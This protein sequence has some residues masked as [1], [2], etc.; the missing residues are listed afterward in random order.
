V[1]IEAWLALIIAAAPKST[2]LAL[3]IAECARLIK[4]YGDTL[5]RGTANYAAIETRVIDPVLAGRTPL[6]SGIDAIA[7]ARTAALVEPDGEAL[8]RC[9]AEI[10]RNSDLGI[11]AE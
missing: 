1:A 8:A 5:K 2:A 9:L 11:A 6:A 7:S 4:G 10:E 3:Q